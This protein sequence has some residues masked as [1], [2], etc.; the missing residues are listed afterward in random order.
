MLL[1]DKN[2]SFRRYCFVYMVDLYALKK[3]KKKIFTCLE[4]A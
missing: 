3:K 4:I 1:Q 2:I